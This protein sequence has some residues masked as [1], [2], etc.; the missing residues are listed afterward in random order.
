MLSIASRFLFI[1][2]T[3]LSI[4]DWLNFFF[5][6]FLVPYSSVF[7]LVIFLNLVS[8][9]ITI[10]TFLNSRSGRVVSSVLLFVLLGDFSCSFNWE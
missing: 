3:E 2:E 9:F 7:I 10:N 5:F 1:L 4:F 6:S 8:I